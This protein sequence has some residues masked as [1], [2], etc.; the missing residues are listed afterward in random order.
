M[1]GRMAPGWFPPDPAVYAYLLGLYLG[2]G[3]VSAPS[4]RSPFLRIALDEAHPGVVDEARA[5]V[6]RVLPDGYAVHVYRHR[7]RSVVVQASYE[8]WTDVFPQHGPGPKGAG[9]STAS[10]RRCRAGAWPSTPIRGPSS[11][12]ARS[13]SSRCSARPATRW[14]SAGR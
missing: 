6:A 4:G 9:R 7:S 14:A 10:G 2:D 8:H 12:T 13:R 5:A 3:C 11:P 1:A